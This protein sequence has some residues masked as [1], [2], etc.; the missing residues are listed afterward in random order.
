MIVTILL[1]R[2][3]DGPETGF[4]YTTEVEEIVL[5]L[6]Y[7]AFVGVF[8]DEA[9]VTILLKYTKVRYS[10]PI[11]EGKTIPYGP[12]YPINAD[13]LRTLREYINNALTN[14]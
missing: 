6:E 8:S 3:E 1:P 12:I 9:P 5:P 2:I 7:K 13:K 4:L 10:I 14:R 11:K